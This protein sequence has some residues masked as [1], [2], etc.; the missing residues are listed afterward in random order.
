MGTRSNAPSVSKEVSATNVREPKGETE[1]NGNKILTGP[2]KGN[3]AAEKSAYKRA[4]VNDPQ[5]GP[6][7][8]QAGYD[9]AVRRSYARAFGATDTTAKPPSAVPP[10]TGTTG[11]G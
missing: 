10:T 3:K 11:K 7:A 4:D 9:E 5:S 8:V 2:D 6:E 1:P